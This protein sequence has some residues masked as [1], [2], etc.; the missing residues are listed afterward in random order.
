MAYDGKSVWRQNIL[1]DFT[2]RFLPFARGEEFVW[3]DK[4][5]SH[6]EMEIERLRN[7]Q[8]GLLKKLRTASGKATEMTRT[9]ST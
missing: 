7:K 2:L 3:L 6:L 4:R 9:A 8:N 5:I 1:K